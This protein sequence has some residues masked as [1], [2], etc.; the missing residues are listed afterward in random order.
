MDSYLEIDEQLEKAGPYR[1]DLKVN[2][3][4]HH[5]QRIN[6]AITQVSNYWRRRLNKKSKRS[7]D[8]YSQDPQDIFS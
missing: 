7:N 1:N 8:P 6:Q 2:L 4:D 5:E 3:Y